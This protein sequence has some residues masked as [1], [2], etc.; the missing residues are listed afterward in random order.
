MDEFVAELASCLGELG[1]EADADATMI[2]P[3]SVASR[4]R[5]NRGSR[6]P[7]DVRA[8]DRR[9]QHS[10][11][12]FLVPLILVA[13]ALGGIGLYFAFTRTNVGNLGG[14]S[15]TPKSMHAVHLSGV[16]AWDPQGGDG[17]HDSDAPRATDGDPATYWGTE[18][19]QSFDKP[20]VGVVLEAPSAIRL[21]RVTV[22]TDTPGFTAEIRSGPSAQGPFGNVVSPSRVVGARTRFTIQSSKTAKFYVVWITR[23]PPGSDT[24]HVS[25]VSATG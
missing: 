6:D 4:P 10:P 18:H 19:Y 7:R 13:A 23:L 3:A 21:E 5:P 20:G 24:A 17:E 22:A 8:R 14:S 1:P 16:G 9:T 11:W 2:A 15:P 25:E 12:P